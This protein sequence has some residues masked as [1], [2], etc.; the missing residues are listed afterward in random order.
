MNSFLAFSRQLVRHAGIRWWVLLAL[1]PGVAAFGFLSW[2][3][4][5]HHRHDHQQAALQTARALV[6]AVDREVFGA[7]MALQSLAASPQLGA[8]DLPGFHR[9]ASDA[10]KGLAADN[11]QL[12]DLSGRQ[13]VSARVSPYGRPLPAYG[14]LELVRRVVDTGQPAVSDLFHNPDD[15]QA[16]IAVAVPVRRNGEV[17]Y[18]LALSQIPERINEIM[19]T[20]RLT[21]GWIAA[22][23]DRRGVIVA[24]SRNQERS[25]GMR[26]VPALLQRMA[27]ADEGF[28]EAVS[29]EGIPVTTAFSRSR[30]NG[31]TIAVDIPSD[32]LYAGLRQSLAVSAAGAVALLLACAG[33]VWWVGR[34][35]LRSIDELSDG[36][37]AAIAGRLDRP[38]STDQPTEFSRLASRFNDLLVA[39]RTAE[40]RYRLL[41]D[42]AADCIFLTAPDGRFLYISPACEQISGYRP[43]DFQTDPGLLVRLIHPDDRDA[44]Q[45]HLE[46]GEGSDSDELEFRLRHRDGGERWVAHHCRAVHDASG[47]YLGR[48]GSNRDISQRKAAATSLRQERDFAERLIDTAQT[49]ILVLDTVGRIVRFNAYLVEIGGYRLEEVQGRDWF[50]TFLPTRS[51]QRSREGF[52]AALGDH[53]TRGNVDVIVTRDGRERSIEWYDT[54]LRDAAGAIVGLLATGQ[55]VTELRRMVSDLGKSEALVRKL[56]LA[57]EQSP[58]SIMITNTDAEIE[59]VND[60]FLYISGYRFDELIGRNPRL[61][62][63]GKT[64]RKTYEDLWAALRTGH[65]WRGEFIN[66]R[67]NGDIFIEHEIVCP[68]REPDGSIAHYLAIKEDVTEQRRNNEELYRHRLHLEELVQERTAQLT[69]ANHALA[70]ARDQ[71]EVAN[72]AKSAFLANM[73]HEIRTPMNSILGMAHLMR[74]DGVTQK[75]SRQLVKID[76]AAQHLLGIVDNVLDLSKIEAGKLALERNRLDI[77]G[78]VAGAAA[79]FTERA[80]AKGLV[81][82]SGSVRVHGNLFGDA[83]RITQALLN[84]VT[85]AIKFTERGYITLRARLLE[86]TGDDALVRFEVAD[87]GIGIAAESLTKLFAAFEQADSTT[88]RKYGGTGLGLAITRRLAELMGGEAGAESRPGEGSTFWFSVRLAKATQPAGENGCKAPVGSAEA[89]LTREHGGARILVVEDEPIN[90]ELARELLQGAGLSVDVA[91]DGVEALLLASKTD[92]ALILMDVQMPRMDGLEATRQ[93][94]KLAGREALAIVALTANAFTLDRERCLAAG[95]NDF[96]TK[97]FDPD[98]LFALLL[99]WL[100]QGGS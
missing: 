30:T 91:E 6:Q 37:A 3:A 77:N 52:A 81:I 73:S 61:M 62:Q 83:T 28:V 74:R 50:D 69:E 8:G 20:Q 7:Q 27:T 4:Y 41:A 16:V 47:I 68:I 54:T 96:L 45:A 95:M 85:N 43:E 72:R 79:M 84:Y 11:I 67:K 26:A 80:A 89:M 75:Q 22:A 40:D 86:E 90:R 65:T 56:T 24:R 5:Q 64:P 32:E 17:A 76:A 98:A 1:L 99:R 18:L 97:P 36:M 19:A 78:L 2:H 25:V 13:L 15:K 63:S 58:N 51:R 33:I 53:A 46:H 10:L 9:H 93:I 29:Q 23:F 70:G 100:P 48:R 82:D 14:D 42:L 66:R 59:Y 60:A 44:Y 31:Y 49:I 55:D 34:V 21:G 12:V 87:T 35:Y 39:R 71:A 92:Y 88:S 57:V 38:L 94:R